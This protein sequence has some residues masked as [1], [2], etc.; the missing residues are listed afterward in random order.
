MSKSRKQPSPL[1][2]KLNWAL[3]IIVLVL[4]LV[5]PPILCTML[6]LSQVPDITWGNE[7]GLAFSRIWMYRERRPLGIGYQSQRLVEEYSDTEVC[8]ETRLRFLLWANS[9]KAAPATNS[10][11]MVWAN[12]RWQPNGEPCR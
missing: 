4:V 1:Q 10:R 2:E 9:S 12:E 7:E 8:V 6:Y 5:V 3:T 11:M